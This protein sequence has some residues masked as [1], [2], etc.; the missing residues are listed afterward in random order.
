MA[1][2][3]IG[4][5]VYYLDFEIDNAVSKKRDRLLNDF[6]RVLSKLALLLNAGVTLRTAWNNVSNSG[7]GS[8]YTEMK[9]TSEEISNGAT[10]VEAYRDFAER[11]NVKEIRKFASVLIQNIQKGNKEI[12]NLIK[13]MADDSW[14]LKKYNVKIKGELASSKLMLPVG[15]ML[16][17]IMIMIIVPI[18]SSL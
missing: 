18:F 5:L 8:L 13:E 7:E 15:I 16:V 10:E 9:L 11:C 12:T 3:T 6:P 17:A 1:L 14:Q 4:A 2:I